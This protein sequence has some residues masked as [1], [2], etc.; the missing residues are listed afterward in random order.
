MSP[1]GCYYNRQGQ[2][3]DSNKWSQLL[4]AKDYKIVKHTRINEVGVSTVWLGIDY[5]IGE[6]NSLIIFETMIFGGEHDQYQER[7][8]TEEEAL[9]GH[10]KAV[11]LVLKKKK[12]KV[13]KKIKG[14]IELLE[15]E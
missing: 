4:G 12:R 2:E 15:I 3:I 13:K 11:N 5:S 10:K 9:E 6:E 7:Y 14:P 8:S 1:K